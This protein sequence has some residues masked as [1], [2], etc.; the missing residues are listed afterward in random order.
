MRTVADMHE[1]K[2]EMACQADAFIALP[3]G[4]GTLE[5]LL[6]MITWVQLGI[7]DKP[8]GILNIDGY[9]DSLLALL[10]RAVEE[11]FPKLN[12]RNI[13]L[14]APTAR[15]LLDKFEVSRG[16]HYA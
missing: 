12:S 15:E 1:R 13:L 7:H 5:E 10:D 11:G 3:G 16:S 14:S 2:A 8:V 6:E 9:Y 4:Y